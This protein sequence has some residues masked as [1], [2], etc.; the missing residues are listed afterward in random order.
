MNYEAHERTLTEGLYAFPVGVH[1][2]AFPCFQRAY[3]PTH[4]LQRHVNTRSCYIRNF[5]IL[6]C[7]SPASLKDVI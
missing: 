5:H 7:S 3:F 4:P 6:G 1:N 2:S